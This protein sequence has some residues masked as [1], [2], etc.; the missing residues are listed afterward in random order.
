M[1]EGCVVVIYDSAEVVM[2][3]NIMKREKEERELSTG[4][5]IS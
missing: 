3:G 4:R 5:K 1:D 2:A